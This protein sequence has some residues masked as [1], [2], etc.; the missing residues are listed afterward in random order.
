M[1]SD[2]S[3]QYAHSEQGSGVGPFSQFS[4]LATILAVEVFPTPLG[5]ENIKAWA[6]LPLDIAFLRYWRNFGLGAGTLSER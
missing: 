2:I 1:P 6:V 3:L 4:A 5:P